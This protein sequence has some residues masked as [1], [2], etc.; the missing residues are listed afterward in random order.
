ME[1]D[2]FVPGRICIFGEHSDWAGGYRR[3]NS[4]VG[5]GYAI[6]AGTNQ[7]IYARIRPH[8]DALVFTSSLLID[9]KPISFTKPMQ[10]DALLEEAKKGTFF[11]NI[12]GVAYQ[13]VTH[14]KV[15]GIEID[16]YRMDLPLQKGLSSS[17][18]VCV[19]T[20][21][22]F[23]RLYD[24][25]MTARGEMDI[26]YRGEITTPSRCGRM[27]QGCVYGN[28]PVLMTFDGD[29]L[30]VNE[31]HCGEDLFFVVADLGGQKDTKRILQDLNKAFPFAETERARRVQHYLGPVNKDILLRAVAA[32]KKGDAEL[33]GRLMT[34]AQTLFDEHLGPECPEELSAPRLHRTLNDE[35]VRPYIWGGKGVGSQGD[36]TIQFVAR[37][38]QSQER[39]ID[40][41]EARLG[42]RALTLTFP[43]TKRI[44]KAVLTAA[45]WGTRLYPMTK[46]YRKEFLPVP[47]RDGLIKPLILENVEEALHAGIEEI[48]II[49]REKD[50]ALF[51]DFF[52]NRLPRDVYEK[53]SLPH[54]EFNSF[55]ESVSS[56]IRFIV[57]DSPE[58]LGDAVYCA[59]ESVKNEP[60]LLILGDHYFPGT[61]GDSATHQL[62]QKYETLET[63]IIGLKFTSKADICR[64]GAA[65][66]EWK[67]P[68]LL[69]ITR[70]K[71]K[72]SPD[73]AEEFMRMNESDEKPYCAFFGQYVFRPEIFL[74]LET[75]IAED[76]RQNGE[77]QLTDALERLRQRSEI[78]GYVL[79]ARSNDLG[80]QRS[81]RE[82]FQN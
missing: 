10:S 11:S 42:L 49:I 22:A 52:H 76:H 65:A 37:D 39:L 1:F 58:G 44:R 31:I 62:L 71:E 5:I 27:D 59:R 38:R 60:F 24:L 46:I 69:F 81:Y 25:K 57:Q 9:G 73:Y 26:A 6:I 32:F 16:N 75:M 28:H 55:L 41:L 12:C 33:I 3:V 17:A 4:S 45:G 21:R 35:L 80:T 77:I 15:N 47:G 56:R 67:E 8:P 74:I 40:V 13:I 50:K 43:K 48:F 34:E 51:E 29:L 64:F 66:G 14:Y 19:L 68:D 63:D 82:A 54:Q 2:L 72:P 61:H 23:N 20:A 18:S 30:D 78:Y 79:H 53:L 7:G 70:L 36:G